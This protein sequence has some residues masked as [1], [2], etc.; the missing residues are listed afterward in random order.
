V[1]V[2]GIAAA[3]IVHQALS[4]EHE[5]KRAH[6]KSLAY[7]ARILMAFME[8]DVKGRGLAMLEH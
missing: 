3:F 4:K 6:S 1:N 7:N 5:I 8:V 2:G